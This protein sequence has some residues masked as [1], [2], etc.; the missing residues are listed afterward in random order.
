MTPVPP[1]VDPSSREEEARAEI[2]ATRVGAGT[3][4]ALVG[5]PLA[6]LALALALEGRALVRGDSRL[7]AP[8]PAVAEAGTASTPVRGIAALL[9]SAPWRCNRRLLAAAREI[10]A[11]FDEGSAL[12]RAIRPWGQL[13]LTATLGY[14][15]EEAYVGRDGHL[16][17]RADFD[18]LTARGGLAARGSGDPLAATIAFARE[19]EERGIALLLLPVPAKP[20]IHPERFVAAAPGPPLPSPR[21][22]AFAEALAETNAPL[23]LFDPAPILAARA[24]ESS[25]YL[26]HDTHWRPAAM[27]DVAL[28]LALRLRA[29]GDLPEGD[30]TRYLESADVVEGTGDIAK[31]LGLPD[32]FPFQGKER[33]ELRRTQTAE[34]AAWRA[35]RGAPVLLLG[36]SFS[37]I[38]SNPELGFGASAGLAERL[39]LH[40]GLPVDRIVRNAGGASATR[41]A[42]AEELARDPGRLDGVRAVVW[43]FAAR[44]LTSGNWRAAAPPVAE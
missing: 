14:G 9:D 8:L 4:R 25:A 13:A 23:H 21:D 39:A 6:T 37:A 5:L 18:H 38:Y 17:Y 40:L 1:P 27:D 11:R 28:E 24:R 44:E 7:A 29:L 32:R 35:T 41:A 26:E 15:N 43:Q 16:V 31:L 22:R 2:A 42:L 36:D 34:G 10:E 12:A 19:L 33:L 3:A 20:S 30:S